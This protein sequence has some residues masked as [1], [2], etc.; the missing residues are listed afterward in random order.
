MTRD[1]TVYFHSTIASEISDIAYKFRLNSRWLERYQLLTLNNQ[2][3][4]TR[5]NT[6]CICY[7]HAPSGRPAQAC[8]CV[9]V[10]K[11]EYK[12]ALT[13][14]IIINTMTHDH[15]VFACAVQSRVKQ[16]TSRI[17]SCWASYPHSFGE[18]KFSSSQPTLLSRRRVDIKLSTRPHTITP[19]VQY[20]LAANLFT[21]NS[22]LPKLINKPTCNP[23]ALR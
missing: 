22:I 15:T 4:H 13:K 8:V 3:D 5:F 16:A 11:F 1:H 12:F 18:L 21:C 20:K 19:F 7:A 23:V 10:S 6:I 9:N 17:N 2:H 14:K